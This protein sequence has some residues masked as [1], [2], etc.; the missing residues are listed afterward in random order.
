MAKGE[1]NKKLLMKKF[2]IIL[3]VAFAVFLVSDP[4]F[5]SAQVS[6]IP[7]YQY[8]PF[9]YYGEASKYY[10]PTIDQQFCQDGQGQ[11]FVLN[12]LPGS[13][14]PAVVRS[15]LLEEQSIPVFCKLT[16]LKTNPLIEVPHI[17]SVNFA[18][19]ARAP[20]G[21]KAILFHPYRAALKQTTPFDELVGSPISGELGYVV[22][23]L[24]QIPAER[25]MPDSINAN[26]TARITYDVTT[27]FGITNDNFILPVL[28]EEQ[29]QRDYQRYGFWNGKGYVRVLGISGNT[30]QVAI[31]AG[32]ERP[33]QTFTLEPGKR[34][35]LVYLPGMYCGAGL[36]I[37]LNQIDAP[38]DKATLN[39]NGNSI[40]IGEGMMVLDNRCRVTEVSPSS[41]GVGG[42]VSLQCPE[43]LYV[44]N[45]PGAI[46]RI[47]VGEEGIKEYRGGDLLSVNVAGKPTSNF[48]V[49]FVGKYLIP[50]ENFNEEWK[51]VV[52]QK[53]RD[54]K[55]I[56][57]TNKRIERFLAGSDVRAKA[58]SQSS[59]A[60]ALR[61]VAGSDSIVVVDRS[62]SLVDGVVIEV[63]SVDAILQQSY[64]P[65]VEKYYALYKANY[66][67]VVKDFPNE[68][69]VDTPQGE[70][71]GENALWQA[72]ETARIL[73]KNQDQVKI[74]EEIINRYPQSTKTP[75]A[76][77]RLKDIYSSGD[78]NEATK[79]ISSGGRTYYVALE[80]LSRPTTAEL[81]AEIFVNNEIRTVGFKEVIGSD[82]QVERIDETSVFLRRISDFRPNE[83]LKR[84]EVTLRRGQSE[85]LS[86]TIDVRLERINLQRQAT[87]SI[88][89]FSKEGETFAN[90]SVHIGIEK[91]AIKLS[92]E[93]TKSLISQLD[94]TITQFEEITQRLGD[95]V[96]TWRKVCLAG[97]AAIW[98]TN[99]IE[100][101]VSKGEALAR[102]IVMREATLTGARGGTYKGW[103]EWCNEKS[104][105]Q[106]IGTNDFNECI[107]KSREDI[108]KQIDSLQNVIEDSNKLSETLKKTPGV[109]KKD[110]TFIGIICK[111]TITPEGR[112]V[113]VDAFQT[114]VFNRYNLGGI[115]GIDLNGQNQTLD[116]SRVSAALSRF[117]S[118][119][120][121][122]TLSFEETRD[123]N[124]EAQI[125]AKCREGK[126]LSPGSAFCKGYEQK[127][128]ER[129]TKYE[130]LHK[131][132][133]DSSLAKNSVSQIF[134][135]LRATIPTIVEGKATDAVVIPLKDLEKTT[136]VSQ[137]LEG[138]GVKEGDTI[139]LINLVN[140]R[141]TRTDFAEPFVATGVFG[142][143]VTKG[144]GDFYLP[145]GNY[146]KLDNGQ[147]TKVSDPESVV[148]RNKVLRVAGRRSCSNVLQNPEIR[149]WGSGPYS[150][151]P[152]IIPLGQAPDGSQGWYAATR[153][154]GDSLRAG[155]TN[156]ESYTEAGEP[157]HFWIANVGP[158]GNIDYVDN[159]SGDDSPCSRYFPLT[160]NYQ[161]GQGGLGPLTEEQ[162]RLF[163]IQASRCLKEAASQSRNAKV[164]QPI[165]LPSCGITVPVG[166]AKATSP[167]IECE[168]VMSPERCNLL[169][170]LCDPVLCPPS[171]CDFGGRFPTDNVVQTGIVGSLA[172][173]LPNAGVPGILGG[174]KG[175]VAVPVCLTG[176]HAG[177]DNLVSVLKDVR[178]CLQEN[179]ETGRNVGIC[180]Q[181]KSVYL[182]EF[183]WKEL[184]P[185]LKVGIPNLVERTVY[186]RGGGGEYMTFASA[187]ENSV[188]QVQFFTNYYGA[189]A[190]RAFQVRS[191][192]EAGS[193]LCKA[194]IGLRYPD[195]ANLFD[196]L[197]RPESP[198]QINAW[199]DEIP[200]S[201]VTVP[202]S[203]QYKV[204]WHI[205]AGRDEPAYWTV[206]LAEPAFV[207]TINI[208]ERAI[209]QTGYTPIGESADI[210]RDVILPS[211]YKQ[212]CVRVN[213]KDYCGFKK[214]TTGF[215]V[216]EIT[217][218]YVAS[219]TVPDYQIKTEDECTAGKS[220]L[221]AAESL[222]EA[223]LPVLAQPGVGGIGEAV[224]P[225][226]YRR[227]IVRIC[228]GDNPGLRSDPNRWD[229]VGFC[230]PDG[231]IGCWL[232][233]NTVSNAI[234][235]LG[236]RNLTLEESRNQSINLLTQ[237]GKIVTE[238]ESRD[239]YSKLT[240][241]DRKEELDNL[242]RQL[243]KIISEGKTSRKESAVI[244]QDISE[245]LRASR[246][247]SEFNRVA[248]SSI[249]NRYKALSRIKIVEIY[250]LIVTELRT[251]PAPTETVTG[252]GQSAGN[253]KLKCSNVESQYGELIREVMAEIG[254]SERY[255]EYETHTLVKALILRESG[256]NPNAVS[257]SNAI[258]LMQILFGRNGPAPQI[259]D[260]DDLKD[261]RTNI[262]AGLSH[263]ISVH[264]KH[265]RKDQPVSFAL[266]EYLV[267]GPNLEGAIKFY[268]V[269]TWSDLE[270]VI[271]TTSSSQFMVRGRRLA[272]DLGTNVVSYTNDILENYRLC[273]ESAVADSQDGIVFSGEQTTRGQITSWGSPQTIYY[274]VS[275]TELLADFVLN[276]LGK[277]YGYES[278]LDDRARSKVQQIIRENNLESASLA[279][280]KRI[281][282]T[283]SAVEAQ[284]FENFKKNNPS[285]CGEC[286][287]GV[288]SLCTRNNCGN[289]AL[290]IKGNEL[291][292]TSCYY[293]P[294]IWPFEDSFGSCSSCASAPSC[295]EFDGNPSACTNEAC[296]SVAKL[297]C[298]YNSGSRLCLEVA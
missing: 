136:G 43:G 252:T 97:S 69:E 61:E 276:T 280:G 275:R 110:C 206:Y 77:Q 223:L 262:R 105:Q 57:E 192:A 51:I 145:T 58:S 191:T 98:A 3:A 10:F 222:P 201:S 138:L 195:S 47:K 79:I 27:S 116:P 54:P 176:V 64:Q 199:F 270:N 108:G 257:V 14:S 286:G 82:W 72:A 243:K 285:S 76:R 32:P 281:N 207:P 37:R 239:I 71:L 59:F 125:I 148:L 131:N 175:G 253:K 184:T 158:D 123:L 114:E 159:P 164:G 23:V 67:T 15:D 194:F 242:L 225:E 130:T 135:N 282:I 89:P 39:V 203:S 60:S 169:Y 63:V 91:R 11:D 8:S 53:T 152:A 258:G 100:N 251:L 90:F 294:E 62:D 162:T 147:V 129:L 197:A 274:T 113:L 221:L 128:F 144:E 196:E 44:L 103:T 293:K 87:V 119:Y 24:N 182:C 268:K 161:P 211:G 241:G 218:Y 233:R 151:L 133:V 240:T 224:Q 204:F 245:A 228:S 2:S 264:N 6:A 45:K 200:F 137:N 16:T 7:S 187:Y 185:L 296:T 205:F 226:I 153:P 183:F 84:S 227:G 118:L 142:L 65:V 244:D 179:L 140:A 231:R 298:E 174:E 30:A 132:I 127:L 21:I 279:P 134:P 261:P 254:A 232:D 126:E 287:K 121:N 168:D 250:K 78:T 229:K 193:F 295:S 248:E 220:T 256:G 236:L 33:L 41:Y 29:W 167:G 4:A 291:S 255:S 188:Q 48:T 101:F 94:N 208:P 283:L 25:D 95:L 149:Y 271:R 141:V 272:D 56:T 278:Q 186:G 55:Q 217:D 99:F 143:V 266:A 249:S 115:S 139:A 237:E 259:T 50:R 13:C 189:N 86:D 28:T 111:E 38:K 120:G 5:V 17:R 160:E 68:K 31:Y 12:I 273:Q 40:D 93:Q 180:D 75:K 102:Q 92:T 1:I 209:I 165:S 292:Y 297:N 163:V 277:I 247:F 154:Y 49:S 122:E 219:Q 124:T 88:H 284:E 265:R 198:V 80:T 74:L 36:N 22:V 106:S 85:K 290:E 20:E 171:R 172:L 112:K 9:S 150:G 34:S 234:R 109:I 267:G 269:N 216:Q 26:L 157:T 156:V 155:I 173:C 288:T 73:G 238:Q 42:R 202:Q 289:I 230:D 83:Q 107:F 70:F 260:P 177:L 19:G 52:L 212:L 235:D 210:T 246:A 178:R 66:E 104:N 146:F 96:M 81:G 213:L 215:G 214:A 46:A 18:S 170:N 117:S 190:L 181:L 35:S 263:L 166:Q